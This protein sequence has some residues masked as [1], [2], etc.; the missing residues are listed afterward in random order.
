MKVIKG[1]IC[2]LDFDLIVSPASNRLLPAAGLSQKIFRAAGRALL[3]DLLAYRD[4]DEGKVIMTDAYRLPAKKIIHAVGPCYNFNLDD[5]DELLASCYWNAMAAAYIYYRD[6]GK[7]PVSIAFPEISVG[8]YGFPKDV[9]CHIAV[10]TIERLFV[11][12]PEARNIEVWFV[13]DNETSYLLYKKEVSAFRPK[14]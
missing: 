14:L 3:N 1:D 5:E 11:Q 8:P 12:Y 4:L 13:L 2:R 6:H 10:S 9:A 7:E